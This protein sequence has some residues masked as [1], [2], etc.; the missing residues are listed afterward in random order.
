MFRKW[1][2]RPRVGICSVL[3]AHDKRTYLECTGVYN[4]RQHVNVN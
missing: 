2:A 4:E 1:S 3:S